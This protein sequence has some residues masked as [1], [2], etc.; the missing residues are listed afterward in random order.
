MAL[1]HLLSV[2]LS[3]ILPDHQSG[4][5]TTVLTPTSLFVLDNLRNGIVRPLPFPVYCSTL[6]SFLP[7]MQCEPA[8][9]RQRMVGTEGLRT[10]MQGGGTALLQ[11]PEAHSARH[12][13]DWVLKF[14]KITIIST[15]QNKTP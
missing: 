4:E 8:V 1:S 13:S 6:P 10:P 2:A 9:S 15:Y 7:S 3:W 5:G 12:H 11:L 14:S